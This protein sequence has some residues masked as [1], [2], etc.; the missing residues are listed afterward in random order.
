MKYPLWLPLLALSAGLSA[1]S[2]AA[3]EPLSVDEMQ[4]A[5][6]QAGA[7]L[8]LVV[9][10][11]HGIDANG[12][13]TNQ[14]STYC[15][16]NYQL[17]RLGIATNNRNHDGTVTGSTTGRK[18]WLVFK[19]IQGT[20]NLQKMTLDAVD[21][22]YTNDTGVQTAKA[23]I[24]LGFDPTLPILFRN[25][26][27]GSLSLETDSVA[28]EGADNIPGYL[29]VGTGGAGIGTFADGKYN[30]ATNQFDLGREVGFT[31]LTMHGNL[32]LAGTVK[33]FSCDGTHPR[34]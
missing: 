21:L 26:G 22:L 25:V 14:R 11:N 5:Q 28:N 31:G 2:H 4:A 10:M 18:I 3:L 20:L 15:T 8:S 30:N 33:I 16:T 29:N 32:V 24:Q 17:C 13:S 9:S 12:D 7:D 34:C 23:A 27:Y 19:G 1:A 6:A